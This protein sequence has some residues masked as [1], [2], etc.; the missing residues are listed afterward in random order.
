MHVYCQVCGTVSANE[1]AGV[2]MCGPFKHLVS[3]DIVVCG[4]C[5]VCV[6]LDN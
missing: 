6:A 2:A 3:L 4:E 5:V 1:K